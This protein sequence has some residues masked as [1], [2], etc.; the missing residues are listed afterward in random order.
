MKILLAL[1]CYFIGAISLIGLG[2]LLNWL[3][4]GSLLPEPESYILW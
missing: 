1:L 3:F 4:G 2:F